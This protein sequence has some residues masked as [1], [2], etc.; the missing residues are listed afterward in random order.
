[1]PGEPRQPRGVVEIEDRNPTAGAE[2]ACRTVE[3]GDAVVEVVVGITREDQIDAGL[4][5]PRIVGSGKN[6]FD[7]CVATFARLFPILWQEDTHGVQ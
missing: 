7:V 3:I 2:I 1:M 6:R 4:R 5:E